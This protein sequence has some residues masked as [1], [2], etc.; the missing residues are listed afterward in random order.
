MMNTRFISYF[1]SKIA[2]ISLSQV[3]RNQ[4][5]KVILLF[6][7]IFDRCS[8]ERTKIIRLFASLQQARN[9]NNS[10][11]YNGLAS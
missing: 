10:I 7:L 1:T 2:Q 5:Q 3:L 8:T 4:A 9:L 6:R 11:K